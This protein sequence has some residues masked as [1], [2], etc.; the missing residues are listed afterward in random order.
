MKQAFHFFKCYI[1]LSLPF[2]A[3]T[4]LAVEPEWQYPRIQE[5]GKVLPI[6][7]SAVQPNPN[8]E[9]RIVVNVGK[10]MSSPNEVNPGLDRI[11]RLVNLFAL[12]KVPPEK[13]KIV[14]VIHGGATVAS[15]DNSHYRENYQIDNPNTKL[16]EALKRAGV[17]VFVCGQ[18]LAHNDFDQ[19]WVSRDV[20]IALSAMMVLAH[21]QS[22]GY[23]LVE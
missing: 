14:A 2:I 3:G 20:T 9:S 17:S 16:I 19:S 5:Y 13:L 18:A 7:N 15:L 10:P 8:R 23:A 21:Y 1:V 6:P 4:A 12:S 11:A 22:D